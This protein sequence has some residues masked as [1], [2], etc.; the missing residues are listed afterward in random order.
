[1]KTYF[2]ILVLPGS[3]V[4]H[5]PFRMKKLLLFI[6]LSVAVSCSEKKSDNS[7]TPILEVEGKFLYKDEIDKIIP[8]NTTVIDSADIADRHIKR[9]VTEL[10]MYENAKRNIGNPD[11]INQL[12]EE[13]RKSLIIHEY[14][15][16][17][18]A[19]RLDPKIT[20]TEANAFYQEYKTQ[21]TLEDNLIKGMLLVVPEGAAQMDAVKEWV[22][23]GDT[24]SLEKIEKYSLR[25]AIS[26]DF[27]MN[28]WTLFS[29]ITKKAPFVYDDSRSF[30]LNT[31]FAEVSDSTNHYLLHIS[32]AIPS[33]E[34]EPFEYAKDR[35]SNTL[36]NRKKS[37]FIISFENNVYNDA[38]R[39]GNVHFFN[40]R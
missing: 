12:V 3:V 36:I 5:L 28:K 7:R 20:E 40:A 31:R 24:Q 6:V 34:A 15:Q 17:L 25:N 22:R 35:I 27:F 13:Y 8:P 32:K 38:I 11:E 21:L 30:V 10:L 33:G 29:E 9:W 4:Y 26:F 39:K 18:V 1:M 37:D 2:G 16:A 23:K 19:E 14:E